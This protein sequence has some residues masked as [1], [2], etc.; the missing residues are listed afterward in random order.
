LEDHNRYRVWFVSRKGCYVRERWMC[1]GCEE[2]FT[3]EAAKMRH[4]VEKLAE[5]G[6]LISDV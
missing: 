3:D 1:L 6:L 5:A 2:M 4:K